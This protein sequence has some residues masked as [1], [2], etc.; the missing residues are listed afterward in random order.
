MAIE[1][2]PQFVCAAWPFTCSECLQEFPAESRMMI[3]RE[4]LAPRLCG[5]GVTPETRRY[6]EDCGELL[7]DSLE[8]GTQLQE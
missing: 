6:C 8:L 4:E 3:Y 1:E 5:A 2:S 7:V